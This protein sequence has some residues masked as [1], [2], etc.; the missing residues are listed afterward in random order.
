MN[1]HVSEK[2]GQKN[3]RSDCPGQVNFALVQVTVED[4]WS[5]I[6][7]NLASVVLRV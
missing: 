6:K 7:A 3:P 5:S 2:I 1:V 4:H